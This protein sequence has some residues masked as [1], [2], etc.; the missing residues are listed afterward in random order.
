MPANRFTSMVFVV[1]TAFL[2]VPSVAAPD[3]GEAVLFRIA[4]P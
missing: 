1:A 3:E 4:H 2:F